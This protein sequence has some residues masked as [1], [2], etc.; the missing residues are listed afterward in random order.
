MKEFPLYHIKSISEYHQAVGL[1]KPEHPLISVINL[2]QFKHIEIQTPMRLSY[3]FYCI[4]L[5]KDIDAKYK[6]GQSEYD[7]DEGQLFFM[8]PGQIFTIEPNKGSL[9]KP[10]GWIIFIH[11]DF[12]WK[13][14]LVKEI[15]RYE[16]FEYSVHEALYLSSMEE[17]FIVN[18]IKNIQQEYRSNIDKFSQDV[19]IAN[20]ELL[21]TYSERFYHRQFITRKIPSNNVLE[22]FEVVIQSYFNN[23]DFRATGLPT[24]HYISEKLNISTNY[25]RSLLK[26]YTGLNTQQHIHNF[27][28]ATAK[29]K[30]SSTSLTVSE[31]AY[32]LGFEHVQSFSKFFKTKTTTSPLTFRQS[33]N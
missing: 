31:I 29:E 10:K 11:P 21:L 22:K 6:Y 26:A 32:E 12:F 19:I 27:I 24:V 16:F 8:S 7:F 3:N 23:E 2:E 13:T 30:L 14:R 1:P 25:L 4:S 33:F 20:I 5:K 28:I 15:K 18:I 9:K 17:K